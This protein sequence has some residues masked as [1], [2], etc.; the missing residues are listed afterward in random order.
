MN[1]ND[2]PLDGYKTILSVV[3]ILATSS[4]FGLGLI[5]VEV[6][7]TLLGTFTGTAALGLGHK[8]EKAKR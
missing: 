2:L 8:M 5:S 4:T 1:W 6:F 3:G 7:L